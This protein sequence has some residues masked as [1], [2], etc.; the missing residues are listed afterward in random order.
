MYDLDTLTQLQSVFPVNPTSERVYTTVLGITM[1]PDE[2]RLGELGVHGSFAVYRLGRYV[3][4]VA[5]GDC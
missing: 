2:A 1:P 3:Q 4:E 5:K